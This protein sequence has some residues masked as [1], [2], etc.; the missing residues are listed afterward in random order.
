MKT[1]LPLW[2]HYHSE[3]LYTQILNQFAFIK[4]CN[5]YECLSKLTTH[6]LSGAFGSFHDAS[7]GTGRMDASILSLCLTIIHPHFHHIQLHRN[8]LFSSNIESSQNTT[9][10]SSA[11]IAR[12][13][14]TN[15][16]QLPI[17]QKR[18]NSKSRIRIHLS[19]RYR[20]SSRVCTICLSLDCSD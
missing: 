19:H 9:S 15:Y 11:K 7:P 20:L 16:K 17:K 3:T 6:K 12:I 13:S 5:C 10:Q 1:I 18:T 14:Y 2:C 4:Q 8:I